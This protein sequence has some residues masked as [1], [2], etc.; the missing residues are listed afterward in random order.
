MQGY[1]T[2]S[3]YIRKTESSKVVYWHRP[4]KL[5]SLMFS[6]VLTEAFQGCDNC[7]SISVD[8]NQFKLR[9]KAKSKIQTDALDEVL[10]ADCVAK[11]DLPETIDYGSSFTSL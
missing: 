5:F 6:A 10:Y 11:N 9:L 3:E 1:H 8:C 2:S 4:R 7:F